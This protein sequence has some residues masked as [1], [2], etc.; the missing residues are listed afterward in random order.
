MQVST[1]IRHLLNAADEKLKKLLKAQQA[2]SHLLYG[3]FRQRTMMLMKSGKPL[4]HF[5]LFIHF[6]TY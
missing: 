3:N 5:A 6:I 2:D 1:K 4:Q